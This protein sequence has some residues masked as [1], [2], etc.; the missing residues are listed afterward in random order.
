MELSQFSDEELKGVTPYWVIFKQGNASKEDPVAEEV[1][2]EGSLPT[3]DLPIG[4][5][6]DLGRIS[7]PLADIKEATKMRLCVSIPNT[8]E[9][10]P[11]SD[12]R[13]PGWKDAV[14]RWEFW[15]Y[16]TPKSDVVK[17]E[18]NGLPK[19]I[20]V[21]DSLDEKAMK[22]LKRGGNVLI[23]AAGKVT[24]GKEVVQQ[25]TPVFWNTSWFKMRPPHTTGVFVENTHSIFDLFPTDYHSDMQ[26][27]E[28]VNRAQ[29]MQ[30]T[31]FPK[32]F[33]PLVQSIDT[34]FVSRK[35]GMLFEANVGKGK[36]V[37]TTMDITHHLDT[38]IVARQ[39]RES[40]LNY[41]QSDRFNPQWTID[42]QLVSDLFTKVA[43]EINMYTK[44]SP[45]ELK[46]AL[47][48]PTKPK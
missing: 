39:M 12:N 26:W 34:W 42:A 38:R 20:Y 14:N 9:Y 27:W 25:F 41:M 22:T 15:V 3:R 11:E 45:D 16:P 23:C 48:S 10:V 30:F 29:V 13:I 5:N 7:V 43:G 37:M 17:Y 35:I 47:V 28:L 4:G 19:G 8:E 36:L 2:A 32:D 6:I 33:Q 18:K 31:D 44:D 1:Y 46:P 21:T 40:I 24:Y